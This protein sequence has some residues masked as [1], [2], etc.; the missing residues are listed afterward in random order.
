[1]K[2]SL[3]RYLIKNRKKISKNEVLE[4]SE[5]IKNRLFEMKDFQQA[6]TILF[7]VS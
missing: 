6:L 5:L 3:R 2:N 4:K 1:M 7:Y